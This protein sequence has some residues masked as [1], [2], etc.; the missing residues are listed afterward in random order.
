MPKRDS[1]GRFC[2]DNEIHSFCKDNEIRIKI[3][4]GEY[5]P[6]FC[7]LFC[8]VAALAPW[9]FV[10][11]KLFKSL[12]KEFALSLL[13]NVNATIGVGGLGLGDK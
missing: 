6:F 5:I 13:E 2:K 10:V 7:V 3:P 9:I 4:F 1:K 11:P 12:M 8:F